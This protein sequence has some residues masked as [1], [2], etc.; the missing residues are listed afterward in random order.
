LTGAARVALGP[1]LPA[2]F[3][4]DDALAEEL[5]AA[6]TAE[7]DPLWRL[8]LW[9]PYRKLLDSKVGDLNNVSESGFAGAIIAALFMAEF[10]A[11]ATPWAHIDTFAWN[12]ATRPG[13]PEGGEALALRALYAALKR[14]FLR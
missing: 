8:P 2:L 11:P 7:S 1:E 3:A 6:G 9:K 10:V 12:Q 5:V 4:N 14:R 13:R